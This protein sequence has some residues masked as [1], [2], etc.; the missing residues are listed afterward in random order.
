MSTD[1]SLESIESG[2]LVNQG[3]DSTN[4]SLQLKNK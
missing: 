4:D 1:N 3:P 2:D